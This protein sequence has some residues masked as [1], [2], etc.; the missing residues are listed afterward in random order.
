MVL[1]SGIITD[2]HIYKTMDKINWTYIIFG[3]LLTILA[4][5]GAWFQHNLQFKYPKYDE[6]WWGWYLLALPFTY[7]FVKA[8]K[9]NV[10]GYGGS[11][12]AGRFVG[13]AIGIIV[14][15]ILIQIYLKE[16]FT[17]KIAIQLMLCVAILSVQAFLK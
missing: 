5:G 14:Y 4:Q 1:I 8:T 16:P 17:W 7:V 13:F 3:A 12:W 11:I 2:L 6:S 10:E 9:F 15:A